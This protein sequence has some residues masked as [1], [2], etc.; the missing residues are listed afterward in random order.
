MARSLLKGPNPSIPI[1]TKLKDRKTYNDPKA[2]ARRERTKARFKDRKAQG[3]TKPK[4]KTAMVPVHPVIK[5]KLLEYAALGYKNKEIAKKAGIG[6]DRFYKLLRTDLEFQVQ[7]GL[8]KQAALDVMEDEILEIADDI[9]NDIKRGKVDKEHIN[10]SRL[11]IEVRKWLMKIRAPRKYG[12]KVVAPDGPPG[13]KMSFTMEF[14]APVD[15]K[16][17]TIDGEAT[18]ITEYEDAE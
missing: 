9:K 17:E 6:W 3:L 2:V 15:Q 10:R 11:R 7:W 13:S 18:D 14:G 5:E 16:G 8:A 1:R 12:D 4:S